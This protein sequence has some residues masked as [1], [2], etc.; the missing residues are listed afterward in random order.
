[1]TSAP[2]PAPDSAAVVAERAALRLELMD[3][4]VDPAFRWIGETR[5]ASGR[6]ARQL[7]LSLLEADPPEPPAAFAAMLSRVVSYATKNSGWIA[8]FNRR[9]AVDGR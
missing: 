8:E 5:A 7:I 9:E 4:L 6:T 1:M 2:G 3:I